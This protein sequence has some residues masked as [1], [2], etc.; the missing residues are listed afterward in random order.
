LDTFS[1]DAGDLTVFEKILPGHIRRVF[2]IQERKILSEVDI[3][4]KKL[5]KP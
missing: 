5:G 1:S 3:V 4:T 2:Y